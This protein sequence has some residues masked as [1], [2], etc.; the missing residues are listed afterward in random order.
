MQRKERATYDDVIER[1]A[2]GDLNLARVD[3]R[4]KVKRDGADDRDHKHVGIVDERVQLA[5]DPHSAGIKADLLLA[6]PLQSR[7]AAA[8]QWVDVPVR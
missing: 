2:K 4:H 1:H 5:E 6:L 7:S 3:R 8:K